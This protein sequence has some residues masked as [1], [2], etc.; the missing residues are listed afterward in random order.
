MSRKVLFTLAS[1]IV[2]LSLVAACG[3]GATP[4]PAQEQPAVAEPTKAPEAAAPAAAGDEVKGK[5]Y[6]VQSSAWHPVHQY[7]QQGFLA[8]CEKLGLECEL[9]TTDENSLEAL[10]AL[11]D[12]T[13]SRE[14]AKGV[15]M[16]F[17][18]LPVAKPIIE[19]AKAKGMPVALPHF[20]VPEGF[21]ADN[22]VQIAADTS[23]YPD[24]TAKGMCDELKKQGVTKGSVAITLNNHNATEDAVASV[25]AEGMK[26]YCPELTVLPVE[27]EGPEPTQAIAVATNIIQANPDIVAALSTTGGGP[28]TWA[29]AQKET[30]KKI[31]A[32]GMD[33]TRVNLDLVKNGEVW[34][35]V[36]QPLFEET[37]GSAELLY[38]MANGE[39]VPYWTVLDAPL[40]T[41][42]GTQAYY[43]ILAQVEPKFRQDAKNPDEA[44][45]AAK[46]GAVKGK[47]YWVQSSAWHPVHQYTQQGFL[48]G[49]EKLGLE[50]ELATT[51]ENSLE[52]LVALADQTVSREDAKGVA[53]WF[54]GLPVAK[55]II[56]K[57]KAKGMPVA[58]PHFPVPEGFYADNAVQIAADTS[59]YPDATAK[60]M[61]DELKKQ[62]VTKGSVAITL[63]NHNAT[64]D[65]V[66]SVFAEGMK[67]YCPEL[68]VLPVELEGPEPTQ[69]IAVATNIIQANPDIVAALSTTGGGPTTWA[70]AQKETGK[71]IL[72]VGM[73]ATRVNLDLVKNGEV[74]GLVAQPLF[75]E[76]FGSAELLYKMANG[77]EVPYWTVLDAPLVTKDGTQAYYDILAQVEPKFRQDAKNPD[78]K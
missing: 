13:V 53:M 32:V 21:Y 34:G 41:K 22:A 11:A 28:T 38:K 71:K 33:A 44:P 17:G 20:P 78:E 1:L 65:A 69:A 15:A 18:G 51:D 43:D 27:L 8:G 77:E 50:C 3:G 59:K 66:A 5:F 2:V 31:L 14:D 49:C 35:L 26:K 57:A 46:E 40:V 54:G 62:G 4:A 52:A 47:F 29:G 70:G 30:G 48:A 76:T 16:W 25:F 9:A 24:A 56:E 74:W 72:A 39:E 6:W 68:T 10:V 37:F 55:P 23:K 19:K 12:Q 67:K 60:G 58:L 63:N 45:A 73:D 7:T 64:E 42:D 36:A 75:E 61:C